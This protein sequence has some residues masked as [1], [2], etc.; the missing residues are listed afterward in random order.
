MKCVLK[1]PVDFIQYVGE[2]I[3]EFFNN[4]VNISYR[5]DGKLCIQEE[6]P[7]GTL[8][9][10]VSKGRYIVHDGEFGEYSVYTSEEFHQKYLEIKE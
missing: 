7:D 2:N 1:E 5:N 6:Q 8:F 10:E 9:T 3:D 4:A